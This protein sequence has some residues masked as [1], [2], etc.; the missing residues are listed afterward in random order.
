MESLKSNIEEEVRR[1]IYNGGFDG[2][3]EVYKMDETPPFSGGIDLQQLRRIRIGYNQE[4][5][6]KNPDQTV[7]V[8]KDI[9]RHE[10][11]HRKYAG[12][13]GCPRTCDLHVRNIFEP[14]SSILLNQGYYNND[15]HYVANSLEDTI[16]HSDLNSRFSL[17]GI[18]KFFQEVGKSCDEVKFT[19][20]YDAHVKLNLALW[21]NQK[22]KKLLRPYFVSGKKE[23]KKISR[24]VRNFLERTG[25]DKMRR[26]IHIYTRSTGVV[27]KN[28][29]LVRIVERKDNLEVKA[30]DFGRMR[31]FL[32]DERNWP[33]VA[34]IYA[35]EFSKLMSHSYAM[36]LLDH[37]GSGT[38][39]REKESG[40]NK[41][42]G[43]EFDKVMYGNDYKTH[44]V[45]ETYDENKP[46]PAWISRFESLDIIYQTLAKKLKFNV[47]SFTKASKMPIF[48]FGNRP[49]NPERDNLR[50][51]TFGFDDSGK[52]ELKK[53]RFHEDISLDYK[54]HVVGFPEIRVCFIDTSGSMKLD[55]NNG[56]NTGRKSIIPWGDNSKYHYAL[57]GWYGLLEYLKQNHILKQTSI[58]LG[59]FSNETIIAKGLLESKRLAL[60]PEFG[61][62]LLDMQKVRELLDGRGNLL[63]TISDGDI[64]NWSNIKKEFISRARNNTYFHIQIGEEFKLSKDLRKAG[65]EV[66]LVNNAQDLANTVI[67]VV[68]GLYRVAHH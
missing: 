61:D 57:L 28:G 3:Y 51:L 48:H 27:D 67:N 2:E 35:E 54:L 45:M 6:E 40:Q 29:K 12:F 4:Y 38:S 34:R 60:S 64:S 37:S 7:L 30:K 59:S 53:R 42:K 14:I 68:D 65:L 41:T 32:N 18:A 63:F 17:N 5:A 55:P 56:E 66:I 20:F 9:T 10:I 26:D 8:V 13:H 1:E 15:V 50:N 58:G 16:L 33:E 49:F 36:S 43:N 19:E 21:G 11:N 31:A 47:K 46:V 44:R 52:V 39:G 62:T 24:V 23:Q 22:Q 25:L